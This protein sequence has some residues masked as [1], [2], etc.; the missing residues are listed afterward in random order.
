MTTL[1][2]FFYYMCIKEKTSV[3]VLYTEQTVIVSSLLL[4]LHHVTFLMFFITFF[5]LST[6][7][8]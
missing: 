5:L 6:Y 3:G 8:S 4:S 1:H 2:I 7:V